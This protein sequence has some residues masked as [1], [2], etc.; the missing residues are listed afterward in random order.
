MKT[1]TSGFKTNIA[2]IGRDLDSKITYELDGETIELGAEQLNSVTPHYKA[3]ILKSVMKQLDI[4]SNVDIPIG[5]VVN[6]QFGVKVGNAYEYLD[7]GNYIVN[8]SERQEDYRSYKLTCYDKMLYSMVD[9]EDLEI[10]YPIT[11]RNYISAICTKLDITFANANDTFVNYDKEIDSEKYLDENG[12]SL[13]YK[14]RDVLDELAQV[15]ASTICINDDDELEIRYVQQEEHEL[16]TK[17]GTNIEITDAYNVPIYEDKMSKLSTQETTTGKNK[18]DYASA[19]NVNNTTVTQ[20]RLYEISGLK[21]NTQYNINNMSFTSGLS[22]TYIYL[23]TTINYGT[24]TRYGILGPSFYSNK[25]NFTS[26]SEGKIYLAISPTDTTTWN[27]LITYFENAQIEEGTTA[28][29]YEPYTNG[30]SPNPDYPQEVNTVKGYR[31]ELSYPDDFSITRYGSTFS[32]SKGTYTVENTPSSDTQYSLFTLTNSYTIQQG[33]YLHMFNDEIITGSLLLIFS[34][35][36]QRSPSFNAINKIFD[37]SLSVGKTITKIGVDVKSNNTFTKLTFSPMIINKSTAIPYVP[38]GTNWIYDR[39]LGKNLFDGQWELGI[40]NG[41]TGAKVGNSNT[42]R[43]VNYIPVEEQTNYVFTCENTSITKFLVYEYKSDYTYNLASNKGADV[44]QTYT[45]ES[46]TKY[47]TFRPYS[48]TTDLTLKAQIEKSSTPTTYEAY[49]E[50][51]VTIP[52]NNNEICGIGDYKDEL[53]VDKNGHCWLNKKTNKVV[54]DGTENWSY[55]STNTRFYIIDLSSKPIV[56]QIYVFSNYYVSGN[57]ITKNNCIETYSAG[58]LKEILISDNRYSTTNDFKSWLSTHNTTVYYVLATPQLIDLQYDVDLTL[59]EGTNYIS[60]S[61]DMDMEIKYYTPTI[62][63]DVI[64]EEFFKDVNVDFGKKYGP[65][66]SVVL[67][68]SAG[69]D[70]IYEQDE[71][72]VLTNGLCEL[73]IEDNQIMNGNDRDTYLQEIFQKLNGL[74]YYIN[75]Y[76]ST[77]IMYY[78]LCDRYFAH[79]G[80][81]DYSCVMLNDEALVTQGLQENIHTDMPVV[82]VTQYDKADK[83]DRK[84]NQTYL[85]VDKQNG[86]IE[87][88]VSKTNT[89]DTTI[90]NNY[91]E[92]TQ[93][94]NGYTPTS[95]TV[96]IENSVRNLQTDTY[97]KTEINTKLVDGSVQKVQTVS[98]TFDENGMTYEKTN[99][100]TK[101]TINEVGVN[102]KDES[103]RSILFSGYVNENNTEYA[104]YKGQTIVASEN[105]IVRHYFVMPDAHSRIEK[106]GNG[107]GMFYV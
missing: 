95:R 28:T 18:F 73:K 71:S 99:A 38:Y 55:S 11:V 40:Y 102:V 16:K 27:N 54:L 80:D 19:S 42:M 14:F 59:F 53:I 24:S 34:D 46:G 77:G 37:L 5:T 97:T 75:D 85:I 9:Y 105:I 78:D 23:W 68:R 20:Y 57:T 29:T 90:N 58:T 50:N 22:N 56:S 2:K 82:S 81:N 93:K 48:T 15:T 63:N 87:G 86:E 39:I 17:T 6:Y 13:G 3:D 104:D 36:S 67:S 91:Q 4:D 65:I 101:T 26:N 43:C 32:G 69:A 8:K 70:N 41:N 103:N 96:E 52:L 94:F 106:Y 47:L 107:G 45:T 35:N 98:G 25:V 7:Y 72:S 10:T 76:V 84:I 66:N 51:I 30:P 88:L 74:E 1:H 31:N 89:M 100:P 62:T 33:D 92:I 21:S 12:N 83:T 61:E 64:D 44:G 49:K 60:N 79:I